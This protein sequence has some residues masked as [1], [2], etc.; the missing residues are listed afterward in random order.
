MVLVSLRSIEDDNGYTFSNQFPES[1]VIDPNARVSLVSVWFA[2]HDRY[3]VSQSNANNHYQ[4]KVGQHTGYDL[5][6]IDYGTYTA[7]QL[8]QAIQESFN[9]RYESVGNR[10]DVSYDKTD[11]KFVIKSSYVDLALEATFPSMD[12]SQAA[13]LAYAVGT[14]TITQGTHTNTNV[15]YLQTTQGIETSLVPSH[16]Y[17]GTY[18]ESSVSGPIG[19]NSRTYLLA[20]TDEANPPNTFSGNVLDSPTNITMGIAMFRGAGGANDV[21][22]KIFEKGAQIGDNIAFTATANT[23]FRIQL[24]DDLNE[25]RPLYQFKHSASHDWSTF[26]VSGHQVIVASDWKEKDIYGL[27]AFDDTS[28]ASSIVSYTPSGTRSLVPVP[29]DNLL[30]NNLTYLHDGPNHQSEVFRNAGDDDG[31]NNSNTNAGLLTDLLIPDETSKLEFEWDMV[32]GQIVYFGIVDEKQRLANVAAIAGNIGTNNP[33]T[34]LTDNAGTEVANGLKNPFLATFRLDDNGVSVRTNQNGQ[35]ITFTV[36]ITRADL[37]TAIGGAANLNNLEWRLITNATAQTVDFAYRHKVNND[38]PWKSVGSFNAPNVDLTLANNFCVNYGTSTRVSE[39]GYRYFVNIPTWTAPV[40]GNNPTHLYNIFL[41]KQT[42]N[43]NQGGTIVNSEVEILPN[44]TDAT[45]TTNNFGAMIGFS[46][47]RYLLKEGTPAE[48]DA[49]PNPDVGTTYDSMVQINLQNLDITSQV[50][51]GFKAS[52]TL[53]SNPVGSR[54]GVSR[55]I[56]EVPRHHD[57]QSNDSVDRL[58]P[59]YYNYFPYS[60]KLNNATEITMNDIQVQLTNADGTEATD[61]KKCILNIS[62]SNVESSGEGVNNPKIGPPIDKHSSYQEL[63]I[64]KSQMTYPKA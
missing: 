23:R 35:A 15:G 3:I 5:V 36:L 47:D 30:I 21:V 46:K 26:A 62:I 45:L 49:D 54:T 58:G 39:S 27:I 28:P 31:N 20:L 44:I 42:S 38:S 24:S 48:S 22:I 2:R 57:N 7:P 37:I 33:A 40:N 50:G 64:L 6:G 13:G 43:A 18:I 25:G 19:A 56:A 53:V 51:Q 63:N 17:G 34:S 41:M 12:S 29:F 14:G 16:M 10:I 9:R 8:A 61:I 11:N 59:Y 60:V 4:V 52:S 32:A 55:M 1:F